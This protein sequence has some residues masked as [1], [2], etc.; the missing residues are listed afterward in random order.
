MDPHKI[1]TARSSTICVIYVSG[2]TLICTLHIHIA[3][4]T[5]IITHD[6]LPS[7]LVAKSVG[8]IATEVKDCFVLFFL[9]CPVSHFLT[10]AKAQWEFHGFR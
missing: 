7:A 1:R 4:V 5:I 8:R 10:R 9:P 6:L 3:T 2:T